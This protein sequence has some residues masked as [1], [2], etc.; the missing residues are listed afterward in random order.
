MLLDPFWALIAMILSLT[1]NRFVVIPGF[2]EIGTAI[3]IAAMG[4][5]VLQVMRRPSVLKRASDSPVWLWLL[6]FV[7]A[8]ALSIPFAV[9][10]SLA[11][12][13]WVR[14]VTRFL[15]FYLLIA[16]QLR[17]VRRFRLLAWAFMVTGVYWSVECVFRFKY[18]ANPGS[19]RAYEFATGRGTAEVL[20]SLGIPLALGLLWR[21]RRRPRR[22]VLVALLAAFCFS[23]GISSARAAL[24]SLVV[25]GAFVLF[26][27]YKLSPRVIL[28]IVFIVVSTYWFMPKSL[29][30]TRY[31]SV[32][33][34][35]AQASTVGVRLNMWYAGL[36]L[37]RDY[38][39]FGVGIWNSEFV[40]PRYSKKFQLRG[41]P[42]KTGVTYPHEA[43]LDVAI[44]M[45]LVGLGAYLAIL[46]VC[47]LSFEKTQK[48]ARMLRH[49]EIEGFALALQAGLIAESV[50]G[51]F[52]KAWDSEALWFLLG[53][54]AA[55]HFLVRRLLV[56]RTAFR[57]EGGVPAQ[58]VIPRESYGQ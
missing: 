19:S 44:Q 4:L 45:G 56:A 31:Q 53:M 46:G 57:G 37:I 23:V 34:Q 36:A 43:Y 7:V 58:H 18:Y 40:L 47:F 35:G 32:Y 3:G 14:M 11:F 51:L 27:K 50:Q 41:I 39:L 22:Y 25:V 33:E 5:L 49:R 42:A 10:P 24:V 26:R 30:E 52:G 2:G 21:E 1:V 28:F 54:S 15:P 55:L 38:P 13:G 6:A 48:L 29:I 8:G 9:H 12:S 20:V 16:S 17:T